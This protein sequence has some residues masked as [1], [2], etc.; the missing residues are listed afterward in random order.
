MNEPP[1]RDRSKGVPDQLAQL[2]T[3]LALEAQAITTAGGSD[4]SAHEPLTPAERR[5]LGL[6]RC[7]GDPGDPANDEPVPA[8]PASR[9][10]T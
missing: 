9:T 4:I 7:V 10:R 1:L 8:L 2:P 6:D 3:R 5:A